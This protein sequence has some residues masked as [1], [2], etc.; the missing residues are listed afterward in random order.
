MTRLFRR[1]VPHALIALSLVGG[2]CSPNNEVQP[3]APVLVSLAITEP[4]LGNNVV[5]VTK[6]T[7]NCPADYKEGE[8]CDPTMFGVCELDANV[9][10]Q[11]NG[12][13][14]CDATK[15]K[16]NCTFPPTYRVLATFDRI[17]DTTPFDESKA[18]ATLSAM[19][20]TDATAATDY[21][22]SGAP[23]GAV[24]P[25]L[26]PLSAGGGFPGFPNIT[27]PTIL[28]VGSPALPADTTVTFALDK[29][30]VR[31][32][33][34]KTPFTGGGLLADGVIAFNTSGFSASITTPAAPG[35]EPM[36]GGSDMMVMCPD[37]GADAGTSDGGNADGGA[38]DGA[39]SD[40]SNADAGVSDA[41]TSD[42]A[43][44]DAGTSDAGTSD[45]GTSDAGT[46]D[47][48][49]TPAPVSTDVPADMNTTAIVIDFTNPV[50]QTVLGHITMTENGKP[51]TAFVTD[52]AGDMFTTQEV[53]IS[54][55]METTWAAGKTYTVTVDA[56]AT[57]VVGDKLGTPVSAMFTMSAK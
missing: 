46:S 1:A 7:P 2:A 52:P 34:K 10:C 23:I 55:A 29:T 9:V 48:G 15:G 24:F 22:S 38:S 47:A 37:A 18:V 26:M 54:P 45:A 39:T 40:A 14:M 51:F 50:D 28:A 44:S 30:L 35:P 53:K 32:K 6:D 42:A 8:A 57:D 21:T 25:N 4:S 17:L 3:G 49:T 56:N 11:C 13:D 19:P 12:T 41:A 33:D 16:L 43:A 31:A 5:V 36:S 20:T 27:G